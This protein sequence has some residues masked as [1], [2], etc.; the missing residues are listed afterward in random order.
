ML[1]I[2]RN[3]AVPLN[4]IE[5][6]AM[7]SQGSGGQNVNKVATAV[8]LRFDIKASSLPELYKNRLLNSNDNRI[9]KDGVV[10][11]KSQQFRSQLQNRRAALQRLKELIINATH[12]SKP[13]YATKIPARVTRQRLEQKRKHASTK[14][15]RA[16]INLDNY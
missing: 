16:K 5:L 4:E 1:I 13:R 3:V 7:R 2:S 10:L 6:H 8:H 14:T 15:S 12:S 11:I 9:S